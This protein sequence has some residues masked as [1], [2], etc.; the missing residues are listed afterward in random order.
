MHCSMCVDELADDAI[1]LVQRLLDK[2]EIRS[3]R[4]P[5]VI[6]FKKMTD[7]DYWLMSK[8]FCVDPVSRSEPQR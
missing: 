1:I 6:D 2:P 4:I 3:C 8:L 5:L 7:L